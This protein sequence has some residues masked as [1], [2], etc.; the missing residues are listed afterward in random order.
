M[1]SDIIRKFWVKVVP[2]RFPCLTITGLLFIDERISTFE[3]SLLIFGALI[4]IPLNVFQI[5]L[6]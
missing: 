6:F 3:E 1:N 2:R 4:N 5:L